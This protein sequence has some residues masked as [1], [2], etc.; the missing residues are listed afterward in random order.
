M[1]AQHRDELVRVLVKATAMVEDAGSWVRLALARDAQGRPVAA[2]S[3]QAK[4]FCL[5][6]AVFRAT[7][8]LGLGMERELELRQLLNLVC[9]H[10]YGKGIEE[11]GSAE[12]LVEFRR[13]PL[14]Y[15]N[16]ALLRS[17][18]DALRL[19]EKARQLLTQGEGKAAGD[20]GDG[21]ELENEA[22]GH[23]P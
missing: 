4:Q 1:E 20:L 19:L 15:T 6:G 2:D 12:D 5:A 22:V 11:Y 3:A 21:V 9:T 17:A 8:E 7:G 23:S 10:I 13:Y 16:D 14:S 18:G